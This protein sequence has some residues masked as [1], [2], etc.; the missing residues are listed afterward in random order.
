MIAGPSKHRTAECWARSVCIA[1]L[2]AC[3]GSP[4]FAAPT[5]VAAVRALIETDPAMAAYR[6]EVD[7]LCAPFSVL[8][9]QRIPLSLLE[10]I[11]REGVSKGVSSSALQAAL[12]KEALRLVEAK[13]I[14]A[15]SAGDPSAAVAGQLFE[16]RL[17]RL[18]LVLQGGV[19]REVATSI[20][21]V[22]PGRGLTFSETLLAILQVG[23]LDS[24]E[25]ID[26]ARGVLAS[27]LTPASYRALPP[28]FVRARLRGLGM[29]ETAGLI[30]GL[31]SRGFGI[32]Q[33]DAQIR[34]HARKP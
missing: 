22:S 34:N 26:L 3:A 5:D 27:S 21:A 4:A 9:T 24:R 6:S 16:E 28:L 19:P 25:M 1:V 33:I 15:A 17:K 23:P 2:L 20:L 31:L 18:S 12:T 8:A 14:L 10:N 30:E 32:I 13:E 11:L 29:G 7:S